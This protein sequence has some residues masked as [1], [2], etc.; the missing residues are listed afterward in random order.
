[1]LAAVQPGCRARLIEWQ[2][3]DLLITREA[4]SSRT[5]LDDR[6]FSISDVI[7]APKLNLPDIARDPFSA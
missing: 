6:P 4:A 5:L 7:G 1:V 2:L 3:L